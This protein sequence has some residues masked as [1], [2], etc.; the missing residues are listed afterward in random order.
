LH[1]VAEVTASL[2]GGIV[3]RGLTTKREITELLARGAM[4]FAQ[5][6]D[7][8]RAQNGYSK[9]SLSLLDLTFFIPINQAAC[10][11]SGREGKR[12]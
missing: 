5:A 4:S 11:E 1:Y 9:S 10:L 7:D 6:L 2:N 12:F 8:F 3:L